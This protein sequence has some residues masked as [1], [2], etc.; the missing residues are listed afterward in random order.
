MIERKYRIRYQSL[1][2]EPLLKQTWIKRISPKLLTF[3][4]LFFGLFTAVL[5]PLGFPLLALFSLMISG[6]LDTLDGALARYLNQVSDQGAILDITSDRFVE[7]AT[8]M[9]L[10]FIAPSERGL[11]CLLIMGSI[12]ICI[13]TFLVAGIFSKNASSKSFYYS[14]GIIERPEAFAFFAVMIL[15]PF[16]FF[17]L[18]NSLFCFSIPDR[19]HQNLSV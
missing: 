2:L 6:F 17:L 14:P 10:F 18:G 3:L 1:I 19:S 11:P 8:V 13:T 16:A 9:G 5:L 15:F 7:F 4:G 12:L